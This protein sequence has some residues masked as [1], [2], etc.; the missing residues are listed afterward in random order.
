MANTPNYIQDK[1]KKKKTKKSL[2]E[3][4]FSLFGVEKSVAKVEAS[5]AGTEYLK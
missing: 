4:N 5:D 1:I 3:T 2:R